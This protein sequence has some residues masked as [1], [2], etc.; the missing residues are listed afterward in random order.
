M[1]LADA[2]RSAPLSLKRRA[3]RIACEMAV[4][5]TAIGRD[6]VTRALDLLQEQN[7]APST[8]V[9]RL[10]AQA[11][12]LDDAYLEASES[13]EES[14]DAHALELFSKACAI[15]SLTF[16]IRSDSENLSEAVYEAIVAFDEPDKIINTLLRTLW[17]P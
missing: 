9:E 8:L 11:D 13:G 5:H 7:P 3:V 1:E 2:F 15:K 10:E 16:G 6:E 4:A 12:E 14:N 17:E